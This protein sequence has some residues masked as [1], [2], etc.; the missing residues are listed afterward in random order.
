M[1]ARAT[2]IQAMPSWTLTGD[3]VWTSVPSRSSR[4]EGKPWMRV[5]LSSWSMSSRNDFRSRYRV[6]P[7]PVY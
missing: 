2:W 4:N 5:R 3:R 6:W 7:R 1:R